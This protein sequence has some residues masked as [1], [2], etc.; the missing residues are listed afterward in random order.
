MTV[1]MNPSTTAS[2]STFVSPVAVAIV[3]TMSAFVKSW[4]PL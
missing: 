1:E 4:S 2:V 3:S